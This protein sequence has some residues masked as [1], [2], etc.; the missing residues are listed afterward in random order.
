MSKIKLI[1]LFVSIILSTTAC[2][3]FNLGK[4]RSDLEEIQIVS[5]EIINF[6]ELS[7][8][9][10]E[11]F[12]VKVNCSDGINY[13]KVA[14]RGEEAQFYNIELERQHEDNCNFII[15]PEYLKDLGRRIHVDLR[16]I[17]KDFEN[18]I[19][20][21]EDKAVFVINNE[22]NLYNS[23]HAFEINKSQ[24]IVLDKELKAIGE[25]YLDSNDQLTLNFGAT[26]D[27]DKLKIELKNVLSKEKI[28]IEKDFFEKK[29]VLI[30]DK[31]NLST[32]GDKVFVNVKAFANDEFKD[33]FSFLLHIKNEELV[34]K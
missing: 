32:L 27:L 5:A 9:K 15:K 31:N 6:E 24:L 33:N 11:S 3:D 7:M 1:L 16:A 25:Y 13:L 18:D 4:K 14:F 19:E 34:S 22:K 12:N 2:G 28:F 20:T 23:Y 21:Y 30:L 17:S 8:P 10:E 26:G 29:S